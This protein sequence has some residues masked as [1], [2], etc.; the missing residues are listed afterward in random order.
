[1]EHVDVEAGR[2]QGEGVDRALGRVDDR[3]VLRDGD[4]RPVD[5]GLKLPVGS[6]LRPEAGRPGARRDER[7]VALAADAPEARGLPLGVDG[8]PSAERLPSHRR[9][10]RAF[11]ERLPAAAQA[12]REHAALP[13]VA[14]LADGGAAG[15]AAE[16]HGEEGAAAAAGAGDVQDAGPGGVHCSPEYRSGYAPGRNST[17]ARP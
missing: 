9:P 7:E 4:D 17:R 10:E 11:V 3:R 5:A 2:P 15:E 14:Q 8:V 16:Q 1:V 13:D 12:V 6:E